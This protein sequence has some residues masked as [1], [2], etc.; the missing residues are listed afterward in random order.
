MRSYRMGDE[1]LHARSP[2]HLRL[3]LSAFGAFVLTLGAVYA[4]S[5]SDPAGEVVF[6]GGM[7]AVFAI[8][9]MID[10]YVIAGE[11]RRSNR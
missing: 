10:M 11:L 6:L 7:S 1:P 4:F 8:V 9:A 2:L 5:R 3:M